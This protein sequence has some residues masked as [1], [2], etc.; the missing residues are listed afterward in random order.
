MRVPYTDMAVGDILPLKCGLEISREEFNY[1]LKKDVK[2]KLSVNETHPT[3]HVLKYF[4][5]VT[6]SITA[7]KFVK[8]NFEMTA[9]PRF[10]NKFDLRFQD[11]AQLIRGEVPTDIDEKVKESQEDILVAA[12]DIQPW[13]CDRKA[14]GHWAGIEKSYFLSYTNI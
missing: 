10:D 7:K 13:H 14:S 5:L 2:M 11:F 3:A 1:F 4:K 6:D 8:I 12:L 9:I